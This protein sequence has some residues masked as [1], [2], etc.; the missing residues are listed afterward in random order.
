MK[1]GGKGGGTVIKGMGVGEGF[2]SCSWI[3]T[4]ASR[5]LIL[6]LSYSLR[7]LASSGELRLRGW[8]AWRRRVRRLYFSLMRKV[9]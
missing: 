8:M 5:V 7:R 3:D 4:P 6:E 9:T 2:L 1:R